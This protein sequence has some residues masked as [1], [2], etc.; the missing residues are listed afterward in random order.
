[1]ARII[2]YGD[3]TYG[4][5][6]IIW[7]DNMDEVHEYF[8]DFLP[9]PAKLVGEKLDEENAL[10]NSK[11]YWMQGAWDG[12]YERYNQG[13]ESY[14]YMPGDNPK[15]QNAWHRAD[16]EN[17]RVCCFMDEKYL[18]EDNKPYIDI[19]CDSLGELYPDCGTDSDN[20]SPSIKCD[21]GFSFD[22]TSGSSPQSTNILL[23]GS[24][25]TASA[26]NEDWHTLVL[27]S[28]IKTTNVFT[29]AWDPR[30]TTYHW[31][32]VP[33]DM[34]QF[35]TDI[36]VFTSGAAAK[37]YLN[38]GAIDASTCFNA[39]YESEG[40]GFN[41]YHIRSQTYEYDKYENFVQKD[42]YAHQ[43]MIKCGSNTV[44]GYI[45]PGT[46]Y[47]CRLKAYD[48]GK[49]DLMEI[50]Y[51]DTGLNSFDTETMTVAEFNRSR[52]ARK[53]NTYYDM[54][55]Y[56]RSG[57]VVGQ[58]WSSNIDFYVD[59]EHMELSLE[60]DNIEPLNE[61]DVFESKDRQ[62]IG[63]SA[64]T[65]HDLTDKTFDATTGFI[66]LYESSAAALNV[67]GST[68]YN[69]TNWSDL[70]NALKIYGESPI[71]AIIKLYHCPIN[72]DP[73]IT[74]ESASGFKVGSYDVNTT[75]VSKVQSYGKVVTFGSFI[76]T[77][78][79]R[80]Y[81]DYQ[82]FE[83]TLHL[84]FS[85]PISLDPNQYIGKSCIIK[86]TIDPVNLQ[87][88][89]YLIV[90]NAII[91]FVDASFGRQMAILGNDAAGKAREIRQDIMNLAGNSIGLATSVMAG[92]PLGAVNSA[93]GIANG[94][95]NTIESVKSEP[96]KQV[97]GAFAPGCSESDILYPYLTIVET[98]SVKPTALE[99]TYG[100]PTNFVG[101]LGSVS[102]YTCAEFTKVAVN[103]TEDEKNEIAQLV[104]SGIII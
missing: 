60:D 61:D 16:S 101:K 28:N 44:K 21:F 32:Y 1:M 74:K 62:D 19:R 49:G 7:P 55:P 84:P 5:R 72:L 33:M 48:G 67:L 90:N 103:C 13:G 50:S 23:E 63:T 78:T 58:A 54:R 64:N 86:A 30:W 52:F 98:L 2:D 85:N 97:V 8:P 66:T 46:K 71:N 95:V 73:Y 35:I 3:G 96:K 92:S 29:G 82:N 94:V 91:Q 100:R 17:K 18:T 88:R 53:F 65:N 14:G 12:Y 75:G 4:L 102:G 24:R 99:S 15:T 59:E 41:A 83:Y 77:P 6:I 69:Q 11:T 36:P 31:G 38:T 20:G 79:Y 26:D 80:D 51:L 47:N 93:V 56:G 43:L 22:N 34:I 10:R 57:Y 76:I 104:N 81:R 37:A 25:H 9:S 87:V 68:L 70:E 45:E 27:D 40:S 42:Q 39:P 89:Y